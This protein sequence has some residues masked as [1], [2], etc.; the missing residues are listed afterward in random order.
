MLKQQFLKA[1]PPSLI[2]ILK[3]HPPFSLILKNSP[4]PLGINNEQ[5]LRTKRRI[6]V[7]CGSCSPILF[8]RQQYRLEFD[9]LGQERVTNPLNQ[10]LTQR[11]FPPKD[12]ENTF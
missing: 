11:R 7:I 3:K 4:P 6:V 12:I 2:C 5:S 8:L 9:S 10:G 1:Y